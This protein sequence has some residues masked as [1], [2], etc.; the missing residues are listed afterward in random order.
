ML[1]MSMMNRVS[2]IFP[3]SM[4]WLK[5]L[6]DERK[7]LVF[8]LTLHSKSEICAASILRKCKEVSSLADFDI[9]LNIRYQ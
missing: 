3:L 7:V 1:S 9:N 8:H 6:C 2:W 5:C 4:L